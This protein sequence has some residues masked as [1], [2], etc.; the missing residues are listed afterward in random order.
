ML[1]FKAVTEYHKLEEDLERIKRMS[2]TK[3]RTD[4]LIQHFEALQTALFKTLADQV[5][6]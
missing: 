2:D 1:S 4:L 3:K 6:K 5:F